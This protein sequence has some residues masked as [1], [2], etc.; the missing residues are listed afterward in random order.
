MGQYDVEPAIGHD[1]GHR[2]PDP[3]RRRL[4]PFILA[5]MAEA[6]AIGAAIDCPISESGEDR[7]AVTARLGAFKTSMLQDVEA[8]PGDRARG[9]GQGAARDPGAASASPRPTSTCSMP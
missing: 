1:A 6:A 2:R 4:K 9:A 8:G 7:M 5:C 3:R